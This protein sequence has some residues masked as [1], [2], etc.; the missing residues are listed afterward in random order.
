MGLFLICPQCQAKVPLQFQ[1][2]P[3]CGANLKDLPPEQRRYFLGELE[4]V[5]AATPEEQVSPEPEAAVELAAATPEPE[6]PAPE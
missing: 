2:C 1:T 5:T 4:E 6:A 3:Q